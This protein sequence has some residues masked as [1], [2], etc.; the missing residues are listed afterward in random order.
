[1]EAWWAEGRLEGEMEGGL[2]KEGL[3]RDSGV[4]EGMR[5]C[6]RSVCGCWL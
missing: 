6:G 1:M 2:G 4:G 5:G 3:V